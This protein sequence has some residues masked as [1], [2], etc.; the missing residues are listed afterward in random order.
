[1][2]F[3]YIYEYD[4]KLKN[5]WNINDKQR[6]FIHDD[7]SCV[8]LVVSVHRPK[9][10]DE[11]SPKWKQY[12]HTHTHMMN[13]GEKLIKSNFYPQKILFIYRRIL[14]VYIS[15]K[16]Y[17]KQPFS[18]K[19]NKIDYDCVPQWFRW[20]SWMYA[21]KKNCHESSINQLFFSVFAFHSRCICIKKSEWNG[22]DMY[23]AAVY[24]R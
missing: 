9:I 13:Y 22:C 12:M 16:W 4:D 6:M 20:F 10:C 1:M 19:I 3:I 15:E 11:K 17:S 24:I 21:K 7:A 5:Q 18:C 8:C 23:V 14:S 2:C